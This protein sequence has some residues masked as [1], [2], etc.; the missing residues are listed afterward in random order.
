MY[1]YICIYIY[2][3]VYPL[4]ENALRQYVALHFR[5]W[6]RLSSNFLPIRRR[7]PS[8]FHESLFF[9]N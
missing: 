2:T 3:L 7:N 8:K 5:S 4:E 9:Y 6:A 1:M